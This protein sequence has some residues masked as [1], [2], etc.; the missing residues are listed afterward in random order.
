MQNLHVGWALALG[1][2]F[3][4]SVAADTIVYVDGRR[5]TTQVTVIDETLTEVTY[6]QARIK[7]PQTIAADKVAE[8]KYSEPPPAYTEAMALYDAGSYDMAV[9]LFQLAANDADRQKGL[10]AQCIYMA[11]ECMRLGGSPKKAVDAFSDLEKAH[12]KSRYVAAAILSKGMAQ[13]QGGDANSA[14]K[15]FQALKD[16]TGRWPLE[17][18]LQV[19]ILDE[20][21]NPAAALDV[22]KRLAASAER[23]YPSVANQARLRVGRVLI[24][25]KKFSEA[26]NFFQAVVDERTPTTSREV[27]AG[28]FNG[29]GAAI[30]NDPK[31]SKADCRDALFHHLRVIVSYDDVFGEQ[32]EAYYSAGVLFSLNEGEEAAARSQT[33]LRRCVSSYADTAW[34][35]KAAAGVPAFL[36]DKK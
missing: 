26:R 18:E 31:S 35:Q 24:A 6:R 8:V 20:G 33:Y 13:A 1:A 27:I 3:A 9:P 17:S 25:Q 5:P 10:Q 4:P 2:L 11:A 21:K 28:A 14:R 22:Y 30:W 36:A 19:Q 12:P 16:F 23:D 15:S 7:Q 29:L 34:G 32:P